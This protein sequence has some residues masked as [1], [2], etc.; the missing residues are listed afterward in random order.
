M[1]TIRSKKLRRKEECWQKQEAL[2]LLKETRNP[3]RRLH[4]EMMLAVLER[5]HA[6]INPLKNRRPGKNLARNFCP[7]EA[8]NCKVTN[9]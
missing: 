4:T 3:S 1:L 6:A 5:Q 8:K 7:K 9:A 2:R